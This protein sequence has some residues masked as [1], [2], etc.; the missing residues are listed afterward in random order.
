MGL[1]RP[2]VSVNVEDAMAEE[3]VE[4]RAETGSL[5]VV[6]EVG[7]EEV[8][9]NGG[10]GGADAVG[11]VEESVDLD[12][13]MMMMT[14]MMMRGGTGSVHQRAVLGENAGPQVV[15]TLAEVQALLQREKTKTTFPSL[16]SLDI[17]PPYPMAILQMPYPE[18]Y[19]PPKF[20][21]F[22]G[23]EG[24]AQEHVVRF[25]ETLGAFSGDTNLRLREFS[26]SLTN[27][28][29]T[30]YV[31]LTPYFVT[32]WEDMVSHFYAKF[33]QTC[34]KITSLSLVKETQG[35]SED[36]IDYIRRFQDCAVD[37]LEPVEEE[38]LVEICTTRLLREYQP[39]LVNVKIQTFA[40]LLEAA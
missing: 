1:D 31:N 40:A 7:A 4:D 8:V 18:G 26:K 23:K 10:V 9:D 16:P 37:C 20:T 2:E 32:S 17:Q 25:I 30:W 27:R 14:M 21:K 13:W 19:T 15:V 35:P 5:D 38:Y 24:N 39:F 12:G 34:K 28:A 29:Y 3:L 36:I 11:E 33:F 6:G 22:D